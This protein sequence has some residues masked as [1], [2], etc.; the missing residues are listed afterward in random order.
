MK[1]ILALFMIFILSLGSVG[2]SQKS[3]TTTDNVINKDWNTILK[4][5][6]GTTVNFYGWGGSETTNKWIDGYLGKTLK[7]QYNITLKRVP[8]NIEDILN[9]LVGDKQADNKKG[10]IDVVWINGENFYTAKQAGILFGPFAEKLP[11]FNKYLNKDS[12]EVKSDFGYPVEGYEVPYG[13]AQ[14]VMIY[15]GMKVSNTPSRAED[16]LKF[17]KEN[18]GKFTYPAPPDFTGSAFVR[19]IIYET[20]GY[21]KI[22]NAK[23]DK[24][25]LEKVIQPAMDYLKQLKPYLW[26]K[27]KTYPATIA[28]LDNMYADN[29]LSMSMS[30]N[31]NSIPAKV[32]SGEYPKGT[33]SFIFDK[34]TVGNTHFLAIP[35]NSP[36]KAGA[37]A[38][39][40]TI[41]TVEAQTSKYNPEG[42]GD[43]PV[44]D[45]SKLS[46]EERKKFE[47]I[48]LGEGVIP[49]ERLL[50][51]RVPEVPSQ[52]VP[53]I[54][55]I[56]SEQ[57]PGDK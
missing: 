25:S 18:P 2:C 42:W 57:I 14:F 7:E 37:M 22:A 28:Q 50:K 38:V 29:Q 56:W 40:N 55:K 53:I 49:Q 36:N 4:D 41:I 16:L 21:D 52:L 24:T 39:I 13:K 19:N 47:A 33:Q 44:L 32:K 8:M 20:V 27:G 5:A 10:T 46:A 48:K 31:P 23:A 45:N 6:K 26:N 17:V 51:H 15:N 11:N 54:E 43:L 12:I 35:F 1:K 9:K 3:K 30:Y 34:G